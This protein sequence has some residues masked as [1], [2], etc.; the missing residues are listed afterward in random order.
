MIY[1][2]LAVLTGV[3]VSS[4]SSLNGL[5]YPYLGVFGVA[6][7]VQALNALTCLVFRVAHTKKFP[8]KGSFTVHGALGGMFAIIILGFSGYLVTKL[9]AAVTVCLSVSGQLFMS[10]AVD[11]FG[12]FGS[13]KT[14]FTLTRLP[15]FLLILAG[16]IV[17]NFAGADAFVAVENRLTLVL[18]MLFNL[19]LGVMTL[20][21]RLFNYEGGRRVGKLDA[22]IVSGAAGAAVTLVLLVVV[23]SLRPDFQMLPQMPVWPL[24]CGPIGALACLSTMLTYS[25]LK[26][27]HA[28]IFMLV[29]QILTGIVCD[30]VLWGGLPPVKLVGILIIVAGIFWDKKVTA[31]PKNV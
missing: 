20:F 31:P 27:F 12:L 21:A 23:K 25:K 30:L 11:H 5:L 8:G 17:I 13:S 7:A 29:G 9:G 28:T 1:Y 19:S 3:M 4:Q 16:I 6:C 15:G 2:I 22:A 26:I 10:A 24:I 14:R 18:L